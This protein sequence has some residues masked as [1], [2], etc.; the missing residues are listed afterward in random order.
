[1]MASSVSGQW[2]LE[3]KAHHKVVVKINGFTVDTFQ[4]FDANGGSYLTLP[5]LDFSMPKTQGSM[6]T[7]RG[8]RRY[9][10]VVWWRVGQ[11]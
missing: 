9:R 8:C 11:K 7:Q 2:A 3:G 6:G 5:R 4:S 10:S 1:M